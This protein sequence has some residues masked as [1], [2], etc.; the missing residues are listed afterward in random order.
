MS[1]ILSSNN[2]KEND[3][4]LPSVTLWNHQGTS[5]KIYKLAVEEADGGYVVNFAYGRRGSTLRTGTK[6]QS[7]VDLDKAMKVYEKILKGQLPPNDG[8]EII[9]GD[10]GGIGASVVRDN[11]QKDTGLRPQL[12]NPITEDEAERYIL[13]D[14]WCGQEKFD[15]KRMTVKKDANSVVAANKKGLSVGFPDS[16]ADSL[17]TAADALTADGEAVRETLYVFDLLEGGGHDL[18][19]LPYCDRLANLRGAMKGAGDAVVVAPTAFGSAAKRVMMAALK[20]RDKEGMVFKRLSASWYAGRPASGGDAVK[21]KFWSSC[22][23]VVLKINAK[24]SVQVG[25]S[26]QYIGKVTIPPNWTVPA[27]GQVIEVKYLYVASE[28]GSLYQSIYLGPR[29]DVDAKEC[30]FDQQRLKY[31]P[32]DED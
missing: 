8:Y 17:L 32:V 3:M 11:D 30:T 9:E 5:D 29:D 1:D 7:P 28:G 26:G 25:L 31:K 6:T 15:G 20:A 2:E 23:C 24:R 21:C 4:S 10:K 12:L 18:R 13:D 14:D 19:G 16:I 22:S 27:V